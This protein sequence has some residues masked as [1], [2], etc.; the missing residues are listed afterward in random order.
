MKCPYCPSAQ[1]RC[2]TTS[3][4]RSI[5]ECASCG[6][7]I[8][9]RQSQPH[10]LFH[11]RFQDNPLCLV[12]SDLPSHLEND[13][14]DPFE[15]TGFITAFSTWSIEPN[16]LFLRSSLSFSGHLAEL[17]RTLESSSSSSSSST[18]VV[19]NLRAYMQII[20]VASILGLEY[21]ISDHAFQLFR[22]CCSAT[23]LRNR[24][25]EALATA[26]LVQAIRE[27]QEP[28]TLQEIS[29]A[30]N[31]PQKE[32]GKYIKILGEALQ[33]SQPINS[34]SISVH[35]PRFC[36]LLQLNKSAQELA[37]H[38]GE[39]VIN[40]CFCTRRN[41]ISISAA[42]IYLACQLEDKRKTQAEICKVTGLT[43]VTLR[44]VYKELLENWD[45]LLPSNY[46]P[47]VPPERAFPTTVIAS[48]RS[49]AP[50]GD[51]VEGN[52]SLEREK[53]QEI[54]VNKPDEVPDMG[55]QAR[56]KEEAESR[57]NSQGPS[58]PVLNQPPAFW[59]AQATIGASGPR[60][61]NNQNIT[62]G[63]DINELHSNSQ[64]LEQKVD[65]DANGATNSLKPNQL[66]SPPTSSGGSVMHVWS[67]YM[68]QPPNIPVVK[69]PKYWSPYM[70]KPQSI[71]CQNITGGTDINELHSIRQELGHNI[72]DEDA[73]GATN[74]LKPNQLSSSAI[75]SE[76]SVM[77][78]WS[79]YMSQP[80]NIPAVN[81][82]RDNNQNITRGTNINQLHS[83]RQE[84]EHKV[85]KGANGAT[86]SLKPNQLS[87]PPTSSSG[88]V[89]Q[90]WSPYM[91]RPLN[92][93]VVQTPNV[94]PGYAE[95][96]RSGSLNGSRSAN[97]C[98]DK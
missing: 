1:V 86:N 48:G 97:Q 60:G 84:L 53:L 64:E 83:N 7:V 51:L 75:S 87:S 66:S 6:H 59:Q 43:E 79:S 8:E 74:S 46:T 65:K 13:E 25:V 96:K 17:E 94:V 68:S 44:K 76:N 38:I 80:L 22:D 40:K 50:K 36:T 18:V 9:E 69:P 57:G 39:V 77:Q 78:V 41:P 71:P 11:L 45:D 49:S 95:P 31:V 12:T 16:P 34:N 70:P 33:L 27:A 28:R 32:I 55:H 85:D 90:Y 10:H 73:N 29:I 92:V 82:V 42:A 37:T 52:S 81:V 26:A 23:C 72:V 4:G 62:Q 54:K 98:G 58:N 2:A 15:P 30:A 67:P 14:N 3:S 89:G 91:S 56:V 88:S 63:T 61:D 21:E 5:T 47:A 24:S 35:M 20:D 19:D 93:P